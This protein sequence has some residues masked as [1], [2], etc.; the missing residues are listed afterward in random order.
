MSNKQNKTT[1]TTE[2]W[3]RI[4]LS[5]VEKLPN[6]HETLGSL[7]DQKLKDR[8]KEGGSSQGRRR[9]EGEKIERG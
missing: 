8:K 1:E 9:K 4:S 5:R 7:Y 6:I 2:K 3:H